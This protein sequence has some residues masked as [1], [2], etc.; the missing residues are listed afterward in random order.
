MYDMRGIAGEGNKLVP[1]EGLVRFKKRFGGEFV[2]FVGRIDVI[3]NPL[4]DLAVK[5]IKTA[6]GVVRKITGRK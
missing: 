5:S 1:L 2:S 6:A 4:A 3:C